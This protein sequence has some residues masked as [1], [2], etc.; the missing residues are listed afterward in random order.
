MKK[1]L[2]LALVLSSFQLFA[3]GDVEN[4]KKIAY[5]C[6]G[7]HGIPF[8]QNTYPAYHVPRLGGQ[9]EAYI[10]LALK[11]Y[12]SGERS[13]STMQAQAGNLTDQDIADIAAYFS[14][15]K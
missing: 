15:L 8:Y 10:A 2:T 9:N 13:H 1:I 14:S 4:G 6:T 11:A 3:E 12:R 7:C 5:T